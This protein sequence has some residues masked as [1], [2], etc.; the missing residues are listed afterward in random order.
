MLLKNGFKFERYFK[1]KIKFKNEFTISGTIP[2]T[3]D[4]YQVDPSCNLSG[5][6]EI[7]SDLIF[8]CLPAA[9]VWSNSLFG[10]T[11]ALLPFADI[12]SS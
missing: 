9:S 11:S 7:L 8:T 12:Q 3:I 5:Q 6:P 1:L 2:R 10:C 4:Y